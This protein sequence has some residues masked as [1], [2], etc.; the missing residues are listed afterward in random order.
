MALLKNVTLEIQKNLKGFF[1][2]ENFN[3]RKNYMNSNMNLHFFKYHVEKIQYQ[4]AQYL[5]CR[6]DNFLPEGW[7]MITL[8]RLFMNEYG[9]SLYKSIYAILDIEERIKFLVNQMVRK[10]YI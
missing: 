7:Q 6:S 2:R 4:Y 10:S 1:E 5:G 8:E 9:Q 3:L